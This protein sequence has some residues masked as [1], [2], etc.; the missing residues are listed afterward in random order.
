MPQFIRLDLRQLE[1]E[2]GAAAQQVALEFASELI[3]QLKIEAPVGATGN[4]QNSFQIFRTGDGVVWL[5]TRVPYARGVWQGRP[6]HSPDFD[7][8]KVWSRRV[9]GDE[10]AAGAVQTKIEQEGTEP[11][12]FVGRAVENTLERVGQFRLSDF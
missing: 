1:D 11:N 9:L 4:L 10:S 2:L 5:G 8:I 6:P 12:D 3:N 7:D